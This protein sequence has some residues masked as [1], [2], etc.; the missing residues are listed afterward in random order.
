MVRRISDPLLYDFL[1]PLQPLNIFISVCAFVLLLGQLPFVINIFWSLFAGRRAPANPWHANTLEWSAASPPPH[2]NFDTI[3][4][5]HRGP[6][7][8]S[9]GAG[10][11]DWL[12]QD[13]PV[14]AGS[15]STAEA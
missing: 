5:V 7:E 10:P 4:A 8:Y 14:V 12:P 11:E 6:Y 9:A 3:P 2:H 13:R 15:S 1:K